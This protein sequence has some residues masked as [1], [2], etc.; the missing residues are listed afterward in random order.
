MIGCT[1]AAAAAAAAGNSIASV[2]AINAIQI[3]IVIG[4]LPCIALSYYTSMSS[5]IIV[6]NWNSY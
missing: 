2:F 5:D 4:N 1:T 6:G 3:T